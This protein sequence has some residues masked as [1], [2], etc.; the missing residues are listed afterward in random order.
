MPR[1]MQQGVLSIVEVIYRTIRLQILSCNKPACCV[2]LAQL[3]EFMGLRGL[4][5]C[6]VPLGQEPEGQA[7]QLSTALCQL[8]NLSMRCHINRCH[9]NV[10]GQLQQRLSSTP[11]KAQQV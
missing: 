4:R 3:Q 10:T 2:S 5:T 7:S 1:G 6:L 11:C 9:A 8:S